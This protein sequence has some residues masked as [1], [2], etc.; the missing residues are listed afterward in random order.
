MDNLKYILIITYRVY[1]KKNHIIKQMYLIAHAF[2]YVS[3][4]V[5]IFFHL[6]LFT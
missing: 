5:H 1:R 4:S 3:T 6:L 2:K